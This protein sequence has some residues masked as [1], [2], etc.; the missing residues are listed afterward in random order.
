MHISEV[1]KFLAENP[2]ETTH[3]IELVNPFNA[4]HPL[5]ILF[6]LNSVTSYFDVYSTS[7]TVYESDDIPNIHLTAEEPL[8]DPS[9]NEYLERE[10]LTLD[11]QGQLSIPATATRGPVFVNTVVSYSLAYDSVDV[12]DNDSLKN[13]LE[14]LIQISIMLISMV[15]N[16]S[17]EPIILARRWGITP[18]KA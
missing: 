8:W 17:V 13:A 14:S 11:H 4:S 18:E 16:P 1:S 5:I 10:I 15:R 6:Q 9:T 7:T 12:M 2:R 3:T